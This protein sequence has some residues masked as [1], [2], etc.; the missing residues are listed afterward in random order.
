MMLYVVVVVVVVA[1]KE[2]N[3]YQELPETDLNV[4]MLRRTKS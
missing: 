3:E 2:M 1:I 4:N